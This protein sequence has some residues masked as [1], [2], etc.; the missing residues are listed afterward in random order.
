MTIPMILGVVA[1]TLMRSG[2]AELIDN[3]LSADPRTVVA[4]AVLALLDLALFRLALARFQRHR[5]IS[6]V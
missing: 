2:S 5:L 6:R 3:L 1:L 4:A